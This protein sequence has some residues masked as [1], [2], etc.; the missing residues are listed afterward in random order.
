MSIPYSQRA[1]I[2]APLLSKLLSDS[3]IDVNNLIKEHRNEIGEIK[4]DYGEI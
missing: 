2:V 3:E 1:E 4:I